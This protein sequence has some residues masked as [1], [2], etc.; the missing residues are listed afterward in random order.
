MQAVF[1]EFFVFVD[2]VGIFVNRIPFVDYDDSGTSFV[3]NSPCQFL[4]LLGDT[5]NGVNY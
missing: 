5:I 4:V 3:R 2:R 1:G